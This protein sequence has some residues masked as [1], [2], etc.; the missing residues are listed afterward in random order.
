MC[1]QSPC[2]VCKPNLLGHPR[3][4]ENLLCGQAM[5]NITGCAYFHRLR[6]SLTPH[7]AAIL[8]R[9][10]VTSRIDDCNSLPFCVH[11][12]FLHKLQPVRKSS[13]RS[14]TRTPPL[15]PSHRHPILRQLAPCQTEEST[16]K[17]YFLHLK[18]SHFLTC[19]L[20][21]GNNVAAGREGGREA[22]QPRN[23]KLAAD[24]P[25]GRLR[26]T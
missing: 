26:V 20:K 18:P 19:V 17:S 25:K 13:A 11:P 7:T 24:W 9:S 23:N 22:S 14:I 1:F 3:S 21:L 6:P 2:L 8:V 16:S 12:K 4:L 10:L 15:L 5:N